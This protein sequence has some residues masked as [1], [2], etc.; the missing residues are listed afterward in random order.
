MIEEKIGAIHNKAIE[1][2]NGNTRIAAR[3]HHIKNQDEG[4]YAAPL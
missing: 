2:N 4:R 1:G 3:D